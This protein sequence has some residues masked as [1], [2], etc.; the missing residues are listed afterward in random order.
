MVFCLEISSNQDIFNSLFLIANFC[1]DGV[2]ELV[3]IDFIEKF[4]LLATVGPFLLPQNFKEQL[5]F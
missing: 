4:F 2:S 3:I 1:I 5:C